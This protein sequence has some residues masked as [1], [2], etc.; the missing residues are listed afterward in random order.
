MYLLKFENSSRVGW[1]VMMA[2]LEFFVPECS[3]GMAAARYSAEHT[4]VISVS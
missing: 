3:D 1:K 4:Q 2:Q